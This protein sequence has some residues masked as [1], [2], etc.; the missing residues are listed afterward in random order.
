M[1]V[2]AVAGI[3]G[4][5]V[6]F[7]SG[8]LFG[9]SRGAAARRQLREQ[10]IGQSGLARAR[11][12]LA[13]H[14]AGEDDALRADLRRVLAPLV[15]RE[16]LTDELARIDQ[17]SRR[18]D[19]TELLDQIAERG[20]FS[21]ITLND[22][23][24]W[25]LATNTDVTDLERLTATASVLQLL[26]DRLGPPL[27][28]APSA[29]VVHDSSNRSTLS[30]LFTINRQR[31][32]LTADATGTQLGPTTLD[33]ALSSIAAALNFGRDGAEAPASGE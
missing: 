23:D 7:A 15:E 17:N 19:L 12:E 3:V 4:A 8:Y 1:I 18:R 24:G 16:R 5:V 21:S 29:I 10:L 11:E 25:P 6:L 9:A 33:P 27:H 26:V 2:A 32:T 30:R 31:F 20:R 28:P 22:E 13:H 14:R